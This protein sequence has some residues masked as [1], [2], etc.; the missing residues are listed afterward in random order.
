M[1]DEVAD[2]LLAFRCA[3][4][5]RDAALVACRDA[6]PQRV[7]GDV[8]VSPLAQHVPGARWLDLDDLG[9][10]VAEQLPAEGPGDHLPELDDP[11]PR[12]RSR[13]ADSSRRERPVTRRDTWSG[14]P[15]A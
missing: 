12:E 8:G 7:A 3:Q 4:V 13:H 9:A 2:E 5:D 14:P 11:D 6:P 10:V 15:M 1:R